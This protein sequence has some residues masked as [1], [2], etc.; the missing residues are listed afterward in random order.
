MK[1]VIVGGVAGGA[2][3]AARLRRLD[4][5]AQIIIFE[6]S[7][8]ISYANCGLPY[9]IGGEI[10]EKSSLT[11]QSPESFWDRFRVDARVRHEVT[12][13]DREKKTVTV[14]GLD[15]GKTYE[16]SYDKLILAPG[17]VPIRPQLPGMESKRIHTL[18]TV[19]DT[20]RIREEAKRENV[21]TVAVVGGGFIGVEMAENLLG[22][23]LK[24]S[25]IQ[26]DD[27]ILTPIDR[28]MASFL[29]AHMRAKGVELL[30]GRKV[31]GFEETETGLAVL[32]EGSA[33][34]RAD[35]AVF[36]IGVVPE[37]ALAKA[38]G[39]EL[40]VKGSISV[41]ERMQTSDP[42]IYAVGDAVSVSNP[43]TGQK[44]VVA[45]AGPANKQGR[46]AA[47]NIAGLDSRYKG[48]AGSSV[49]KIF[50]M[51]AAFTG[52]NE[53]AA[54]AAGLDYEKILL[55]PMSHASYYPGG[56]VMTM[57]LLFEKKSGRILGAQIVGFDG[58][59]KRLDVIATAMQAGMRVF[60][61]KDLDL[62]YA[63][64]YSSAKDPV[65]MAGFIAENVATGKVKQFFYEDI[66]K[67]PRDGSVILLDTRTDGEYMRGH[68]DGFDTHIPVDD[69]RERLDE[70]DRAKPVYVMCQSGLRSYIA[71]R[72]L[73]QEGFD[74][75]NF[76]GGYRVYESVKKDAFDESC[77]T[78]CG[79]NR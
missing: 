54:K 22:L 55:S 52:L 14:R 34:L 7:G 10:K 5:K 72:I 21:K 35:M 69:L 58:V 56:R 77:R 12:A 13:V 19:E 50:E 25:L 71:C 29:H 67:L 15:T 57:K 76:A 66:D 68:A 2:T 59:D 18:R 75:Y 30:L 31:T 6:R 65:N 62:A 74:C 79:L 53:Q 60:E 47:D 49:L 39:L 64:P 26:L 17:A 46:V 1:V 42:D 20:L 37:S 41:N 24:V 43:V 23:G 27:Q 36:A 3:A 78:D 11:L 4:E 48:S 32:L 61:L 40:G 45:L 16:E 28:D 33:S 9:Y 70:L 73:A 51:T 8:Y 44:A 63:P 38:A